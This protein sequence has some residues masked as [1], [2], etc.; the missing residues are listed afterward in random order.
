MINNILKILSATLVIFVFALVLEIS[1][2]GEISFI[3]QDKNTNFDEL[4]LEN[5]SLAIS[6]SDYIL[7]DKGLFSVKENF[8]LIPAGELVYLD[9]YRIS[10]KIRFSEIPARL[11][12]N[13]Y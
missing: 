9:T 10:E 8:N 13:R 5:E 6:Y 11:P 4:K 12:Q 3:I 1:S 2:L 7:N